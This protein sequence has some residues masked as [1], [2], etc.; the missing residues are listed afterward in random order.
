MMLRP[1]A[2][3][4]DENELQFC[5][6]DWCA[7]YTPP[8]G[9]K[10]DT[11]GICRLVRRLGISMELPMV[12]SELDLIRDQK[13]RIVTHL[14]HLKSGPAYRYGLANEQNIVDDDVLPAYR[15]AIDNAAIY[16]GVVLIFTGVIKGSTL[17]GCVTRFK[18]NLSTILEYASEK[19]VVLVLE[20]L[21]DKDGG[22]PDS[23]R[24]H[25]DYLGRNLK[26]V[27]R[28]V[29]EFNSPFLKLLFDV[30][31]VAIMHPQIYMQ[32]LEDNIDII[33]HIHVAGILDGEPSRVELDAP[34]QRIDYKAVGA[35][36]RRL[37]YKGFVGFEWIT[38]A[39]RGLYESYQ[40][41]LNILRA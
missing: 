6:A 30:Y 25:K 22:D 40:A 11:D 4:D 7:R 34:G 27:A 9:E 15:Q 21:N 35:L 37:K 14:P 24:G 12:T 31:H 18:K 23:M 29:R 17:K 33:G 28:W 13:V 2:S 26:I 19:K 16:G 1:K 38:T 41:A 8:D 39:G 3:V 20:H 5:A 36:L 10:L 32:L